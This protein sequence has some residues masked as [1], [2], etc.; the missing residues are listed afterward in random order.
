MLKLPLS[1]PGIQGKTKWPTRRPVRKAPPQPTI[2]APMTALN[3]SF[4]RPAARS[5]SGCH[6]AE[7]TAA[8]PSHT[9]NPACSP[10]LMFG[11]TMAFFAA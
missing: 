4:S 1:Q 6:S 10:I 8:D 9:P 7:Q 11:S 5:P 3:G 2:V